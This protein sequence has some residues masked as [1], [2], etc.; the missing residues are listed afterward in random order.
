MGSSGWQLS[1]LCD[2]HTH[3]HT[4]HNIP[5]AITHHV[6][7][8]RS[9]ILTAVC[10]PKLR[11]SYPSDWSGIVQC[12]AQH[13]SGMSALHPLIQIQIFLWCGKGR[14]RKLWCDYRPR[15]PHHPLNCSCVEHCIL[16]CIMYVKH[17][18]SWAILHC[19][20]SRCTYIIP[21]TSHRARTLTQ[22]TCYHVHAYVYM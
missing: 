2:N 16:S 10:I 9:F 19:R 20:F 6:R 13:T 8:F 18:K 12:S 1:S 14:A 3:T 5:I 17:S 21:W 7:K 4:Y 15:P 22:T 11:G